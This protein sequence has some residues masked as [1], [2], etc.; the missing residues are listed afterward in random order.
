MHSYRRRKGCWQLRADPWRPQTHDQ[1]CFISL[2]DFQIETGKAVDLLGSLVALLN[3]HLHRLGFLVGDEKNDVHVL[4]ESHG[5][6]GTPKNLNGR[7]GIL[8][9]SELQSEV[10]A[11]LLARLAAEV[12]IALDI[13]KGTRDLIIVDDDAG[14]KLVNGLSEQNRF[15]I[16][17]LDGEAYAFGYVST[18]MAE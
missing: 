11:A 15:A 16:L 8:G 7:S 1:S 17:G 5:T 10:V 2:I 14:L 18:A 9:S 3:R 4:I 12:G 6:L 13:M